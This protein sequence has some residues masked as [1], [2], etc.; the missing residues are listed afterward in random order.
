[1][2]HSESLTMVR[3]HL[4][5]MLTNEDSTFKDIRSTEIKYFYLVLSGSLYEKELLMRRIA[6]FVSIADG[7]RM[8]FNYTKATRGCLKCSRS[9]KPAPEKN[10]PSKNSDKR[11][12]VIVKQL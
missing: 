10:E 6:A 4:A 3:K 8:T 1:M 9:G 12:H 7:V 11:Y 2:D 5:L